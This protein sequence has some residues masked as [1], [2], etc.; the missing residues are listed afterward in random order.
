[1]EALL[2]TPAFQ[3]ELRDARV[4]ALLAVQTAL[5]THESAL[6]EAAHAALAPLVQAPAALQPL[7]AFQESFLSQA[8]PT[9]AASI[10][11]QTLLR[12]LWRD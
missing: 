12:M 3:R 8:L 2:L 1:M 6:A 4:E 11:E 9:L 5:E 7:A 10:V